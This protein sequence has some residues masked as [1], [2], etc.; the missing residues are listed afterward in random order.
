[1]F[2]HEGVAC[3]L[4]YVVGCD[5]AWRTVSATITGWV[6]ER[7]IDLEVVVDAARRWS[8]NG[9]DSPGVAGCFDIDLAFSP[10]TNTLPIR[11]LSL[12]AGASALVRAAWLTFPDFTLQPLDQ[13]YQRVDPV[14]YRYESGGGAFRATLRTNPAGLVISYPDLWEAVPSERSA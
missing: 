11:R 1:M 5:A 8:L 7:A 4:G 13:V 12:A 2:G 14:T 3:S 9:S 6:G 10:S